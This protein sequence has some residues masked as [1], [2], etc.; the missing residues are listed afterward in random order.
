MSETARGNDERL[1]VYCR[2]WCGD[3]ARAFRWLDSRGI[4]YEKRDVEESEEA[5][6]FAESVNEGRLHTPTFA[7]GESVCVDLDIPWLCEM[8]GVE[9]DL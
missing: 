1:I 9:P 4:E 8:L 3:C 2:S 6:E 5:R 7:I